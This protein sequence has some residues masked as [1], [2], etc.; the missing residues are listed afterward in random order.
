MSNST[1]LRFE[2]PINATPNKVWDVLWNDATYRQ[3]TAPF[4]AGSYAESDWKEGSSV[5]FLGPDG[6]GMNSVIKKMDAPHT[7]IFEHLGEVKNYE[8]QPEAE[9]KGAT[10]A[11]YLTQQGS[12][13]LLVAEMDATETFA[14]Y[15]N[16]AFP[17][18]LDKVKELSEKALATA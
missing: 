2:V 1:K 18:A 7:M 15:M 8:V 4:C 12:G 17:K 14:E 6:S 10:E 11:Y 3:W 16:N 9:W 5:K 13:T